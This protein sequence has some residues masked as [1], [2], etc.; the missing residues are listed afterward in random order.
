MRVSSAEASFLTP[1]SSR[2]AVRGKK[3]GVLFVIASLIGVSDVA[4]AQSKAKKAEPASSADEEDAKKASRRTPHVP[5]PLLFLL[6]DEA[7]QA[8]LKMRDDQKK[9]IRMA[10]DEID[11]PLWLLRDVGPDEGKG[12]AE[13][14][15]AKVKRGLDGILGETQQKRLDQITLQAQ[16][17]EALFLPGVAQKLGLSNDQRQQVRQAIE[18]RQSEFQELMNEA[19]N[20]KDPDKV[21]VF[22]EKAAKIRESEH[23]QLLIVLDDNQKKQWSAML[24]K[25]IDLTHVQMAKIKA[26][27]I[28]SPEKWINS[29]PITL[30][31]LRGRVV[32]MHFWTF[33][34]INCIRNYP[35]YKDWHEK[36]AP[37]GLT[38]IG[39]HTP[40][41]EG[42]K[43]QDAVQKKIEENEIQYP[44]AIDNEA[45][46]WK[47]WA[48]SWWPSTYLIDKRGYV[49]YWWYGELNWEGRE[50]EKFMRQKIEEL[51]AEPE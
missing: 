29:E 34:C 28:V 49:R 45:R 51:L 15:I 20:N 25:T 48:N 26:P 30:P 6:R 14:L 23:E 39:I 40:E 11:G 35:W 9:A 36:Y 47:A 50:G 2:R 10:L 13:E 43:D 7:V 46:T 44:V 24:G 8:E 42:E 27:E 3:F 5:N 12:R 32:A 21:K 4:V 38:V 1:L 18:M 19:A 22:Q 37:K 16:G 41:S 17:P 31:K 33:G